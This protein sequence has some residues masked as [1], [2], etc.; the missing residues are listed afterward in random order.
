MS[1]W[2]TRTTRETHR[3][4]EASLHETPTYGGWVDG[5]GPRYC[6]SIEDKVRRGG[7]WGCMC[8]RVLVRACVRVTVQVVR[9]REGVWRRREQMSCRLTR[10]TSE[11]HRLVEASLHETPTYGGWVDGRGPRY[12][13]SIEDKVRAYATPTYGG[14][15]EWHQIM[16]PFLL[17][18]VLLPTCFISS[19]QTAQIVRFRDK[20][21][22]PDLHSSRH[23]Q[24][25]HSPL[26]C[27][28]PTFTTE[29]QLKDKESHLIFHA[30][31]VSVTSS[32]PCCPF[33]PLSAPCCPFL[34]L[35]APF[36]PLLPISAPCCP[37][38]PLAAPFCPLLPLSPPC[39]PLLCCPLLPLSA[40]FCPFLPLA[41]PCCPSLPLAAPFC[42]FQPLSAPF[43]PFL[44]LVPS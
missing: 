1:C 44:P 35:A 27:M 40:P 9:V 26:P 31:N 24:A 37:F 14:D 7:R 10:T 17:A 5:R 32:A 2:L 42:P 21:V 12:C 18:A 15:S 43:C 33:L 22:L 20:G 3:L 41:A 16:F 39:C 23:T 29:V 28:R 19:P 6:P 13:P 34:P 36:C 25:S 8:A 4:V 38:L 11:T 30:P